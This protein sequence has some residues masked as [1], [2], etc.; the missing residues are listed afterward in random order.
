MELSIEKA[1]NGYVVKFLEEDEEGNNYTRKVV[2][3]E[4]EEYNNSHSERKSEKK[5]MEYLLCHIMDYFGIHNSKHDK[6]RLEIEVKE[7]NKDG[8]E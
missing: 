2:F 5:C 1:I 7:Q 4:E 6:Y 8:D 3:E